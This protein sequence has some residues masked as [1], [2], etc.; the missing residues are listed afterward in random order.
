MY[1]EELKHL[2][3]AVVASDSERARAEASEALRILARRRELFFAGEYEG[4]SEMEDI[5]LALEGSAMWVQCQTALRLAPKGQ[6]WLDT[7][8]ILGQRTDAWSQSQGL[9]LFLLLDR[10]TPR[11]QAKFFGGFVPS[12]V[13]TLRQ[14]LASTSH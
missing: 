11:W 3:A 12:P 7:L 4:W 9:G 1:N 6:P 5:F 2:S 14:A 8:A 10:F 13:E